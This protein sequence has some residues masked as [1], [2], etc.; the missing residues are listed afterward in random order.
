MEADG[1]SVA[2]LPRR[3]KSAV[4]WDESTEKAVI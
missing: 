2:L 1:T 4:D 3:K